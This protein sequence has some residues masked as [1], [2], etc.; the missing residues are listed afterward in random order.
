[1][2]LVEKLHEICLSKGISPQ[3]CTNIA[4]TI[5]NEYGGG[6]LYIPKHP[7]NLHD[8]IARDLALSGDMKGIARKH[9][10]SCS[11]VRRVLMRRR[12]R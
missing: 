7:S 11:T 8:N 3:I 6:V 1:M 12:R 5:R 10:V 2:D 9:G 4:K